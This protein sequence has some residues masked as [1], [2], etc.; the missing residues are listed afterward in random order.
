MG[1]VERHHKKDIRGRRCTEGGAAIIGEGNTLLTDDRLPKGV[2]TL[3]TIQVACAIWTRRYTL[4]RSTRR[5]LNTEQNCLQACGPGL[6]VTT[7]DPNST[8]SSCINSS[9]A[10]GSTS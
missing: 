6:I 9:T 5:Y 7:R 2:L 3:V 8:A 4:K 10:A 1:P